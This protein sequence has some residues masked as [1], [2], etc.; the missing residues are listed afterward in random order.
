MKILFPLTNKSVKIYEDNLR[1]QLSPTERLILR[2]LQT[3]KNLN[4]KS[5][6]ESSSLSYRQFLRKVDEL[7]TKEIIN[8]WV[9]IV[10]PL[11]R[12][13]KKAVFLF[14]K[15]NPKGPADLDYLK[16]LEGQLLSLDGVAGIF[17]LLA[18][19]Q[20][21]NDQEFNLSLTK[22]EDAFKVE[23]PV[24]EA[25]RYQ[26]LEII[27]FYKF[28]GFP[29]NQDVKIPTPSE[30]KLLDKLFEIG[31]DRNRPP[32]IEE[33]SNSLNM[34]NSGVQK[35]LKSLEDSKIILGYGILLNRLVRP[36]VKMIIQFQ[37]HPRSL[38]D[39]IAFFQEDPHVTL[40]CKTQSDKYSLLVMA[41]FISIQNFNIWIKE[42]YKNDD[43]LDTLTTVSLN[44]EEP[45]KT[46]LLFPI[47]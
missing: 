21:Q 25:N 20:F 19:I 47:L 12:Q 35:N 41:Y 18:L 14:L 30:K 26:F 45:S 3:R 1:M 22:I 27:S 46:S 29:I 39:I 17:S 13:A 23:D 8:G 44:D 16:S 24:R 28:N 11:V 5:S 32:T 15:T 2:D 37:I 7:Y 33:L 4:L 36:S 42:V 10:H 31:N 43:I 9:P 6:H 34:S 38:I 40:L